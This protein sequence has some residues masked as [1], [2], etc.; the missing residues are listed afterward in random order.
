M[1]IS[2]QQDSPKGQRSSG[3]PFT[4]QMLTQGGLSAQTIKFP[5]TNMTSRTTRC[6]SRRCSA[7]CTSTDFHTALVPASRWC[8]PETSSCQE[9]YAAQSYA[10]N[11]LF[12]LQRV[13]ASSRGIR[14]AQQSSPAA[15]LPKRITVG[16]HRGLDV[17]YYSVRLN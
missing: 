17:Q 2:L 15:P 9:P 14:V 7:C 10:L 5:L 6:S 1:G 4:A 13:T 8:L 11:E 12:Y 3:N 16:I